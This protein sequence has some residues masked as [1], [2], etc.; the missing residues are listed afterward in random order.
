MV[1]RKPAAGSRQQLE[2]PPEPAVTKQA[3]LVLGMHRCGTSAVT[4]MLSLLGADLPSQLM[5][6]EPGANELGFWESQE[7]V[8]IH[9]ELLAAAGSSWDD[10]ADFLGS[11]F[12]TDQ[13][14]AFRARLL[15]V[16]NRD[17]SSSE[18]FV[19]KD[20][21]LC[22]LVPLW[23]RILE[24]FGA[25]PSFVLPLRNPLEVAESLRAL[26]GLTPA[27]SHLLW[28]GHVLASEG[29]TRGC[30]R[31]LI[32]YEALLRDWRA[33]AAKVSEDLGISWPRRGNRSAAEI[34]RFL[35]DRYRHYSIPDEQLEARD[36]VP[37][38]VKSV[39]AAMAGAADGKADP[40]PLLNRVRRGM[41]A[42]NHAFGPI[43]VED[44][45][46]LA[47]ERRERER[48]GVE[49]TARDT[50]IA[51]LKPQLAEKQAEIERLAGE[52]A[53]LN[54][55]TTRL[56][57]LASGQQEIMERLVAWSAASEEAS[58]TGPGLARLQA[59]IERLGAEAASRDEERLR[60]QQQQA[61]KRD[62]EVAQLE[63]EA[64]RRDEE[65]SRLQAEAR[66]RDEKVARLEAEL[67]RRDELVA[68]LE[69][70]AS[71]HDGTVARLEA[72]AGRYDEQVLH[73]Q[74]EAAR[75][76]E[77]IG[78]LQ[79]TVAA[80]VGELAGLTRV[81]EE[82]RDARRKLKHFVVERERRIERLEK[83]LAGEQE[84]VHK[85]LSQL[86]EARADAQAM[87]EQLQDLQRG[88]EQRE[89]EERLLLM[90]LISEAD[91]AAR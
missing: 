83:A 1:P 79:Q 7:I 36:E 44:R 86:A 10:V 41:R 46:L 24:D 31:S 84:E 34:D 73:L 20:P 63:G 70:E 54:G 3:I 56:Q 2:D 23:R 6:A 74:S 5:P 15:E 8:D 89:Q 22:R 61:A 25:A 47:A 81:V 80:S 43:V 58:R 13:A 57:K 40:T 82:Q 69:A 4:R 33:V 87:A 50:T 66:Q 72:A 76:N 67:R 39:W 12:E 52:K 9:D 48:L 35:S 16:L 64:R 91:S 77:E 21:R 28:L 88:L 65:V 55:W 68:R 14:E 42:A 38:W 90:D 60:L 32:T 26:H 17:F 62:E 59:E 19:L 29:E 45:Q 37:T 78:R 49:L 30:R 85:L 51:E 18:L 11:W 53:I 27:R 75:R 71:Q